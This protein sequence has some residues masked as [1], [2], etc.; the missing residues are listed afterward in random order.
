M[1]TP[2]NPTLYE[3]AKKIADEK[4][5][6]PSAYKS[7][8]IVKTYKELGGKYADDGEPMKLKRWFKEEWMD[9]GGKDYPTYRPTKR[10]SKDTPLTYKEIDP[11]NLREQIDLKQKIKGESNLPPF[12]EKSSTHS[13]NKMP[14]FAK[15]S[16]EAKDYM[17]SIRKKK[18]K[19]AGFLDVVRKVGSKLG[20]PFKKKVGINPFDA[21]FN[22]GKDVIAPQLFKVIPPYK[23]YKAKGK[24]LKEQF[25]EE[26]KAKGG[27]S[28]EMKDRYIS[29]LKSNK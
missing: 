4:Y 19:G 17:A 7:G 22:L 12:R 26:V 27:L 29:M 21:G 9:V 11:T 25:M 6:K 18:T 20:D 24:G 2:T 13:I 5:E 3:R 16:Q 10:V 28:Q 15:G 23:G 14:K 1:P 8:F